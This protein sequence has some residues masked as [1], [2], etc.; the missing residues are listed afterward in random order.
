MREDDN[1]TGIVRRLA[2]Q[3]GLPLRADK[4]DRLRGQRAPV[5]LD[6]NPTRAVHRARPQADLF[7]SEGR[8][9]QFQHDA[10]HILLD[11][12]IVARELQIVQRA[13]R[14]EEKRI[15]APTGEEAA[16][17]GLR[18]ICVAT[19]R[20]RCCFDDDLA[21]I[22]RSG[23]LHALDAPQCRGLR[24]TPE[25]EKRTRNAMS[26]TASP[27]VSIL[28]SYDAVGAKGSRVVGPGGFTT[29]EGWTF[30]IRIDLPASPGFGKA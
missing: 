19:R 5:S 10:A 20:D 27:F 21:A 4:K 1:E 6:P 15:A 11:E 3:I 7:G 24:P 2:G 9:G 13:L 16:P 22:P 29:A 25:E 26:A 14:V 30:M 18:H 8:V 17:A 23:G 12:E 28:N